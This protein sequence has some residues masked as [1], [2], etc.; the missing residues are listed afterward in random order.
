MSCTVAIFKFV[1]VNTQIVNRTTMSLLRILYTLQSRFYIL[2]DH[3]I[4]TYI[5]YFTKSI[6][7]S[8]WPTKRFALWDFLIILN[9]G[10]L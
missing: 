10:S 1:A 3:L 9:D 4:N 5:V 6:L 7:L 2:F 8:I